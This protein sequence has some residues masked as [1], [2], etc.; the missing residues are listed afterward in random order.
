MD[1]NKL[2]DLSMKNIEAEL[3]FKNAKIVNVFSHEIVNGDVAINEGIIVGI[4]SYDGKKNI[5]IEGKYI[6][7]GLIDSHLHIESVMVTPQ[8][9]AKA[10]VPRGTTTAISDPH[11]IA[12]VCGLDG[13]DYML[14][15]SKNLPIDIYF[16]LPSCVPA[17][18]FEDSGA[19]LNANELKDL[20]NNARVLG[21]GEMMN[22]PGVIYKD[23][24]VIEKLELASKNNKIIDGHGPNISNEKL[25]AYVISGVSTEH[26]CSTVE[27]MIDRIRLGMYVMIR[28]GSAAKNLE[29]LVNGINNFNYQRCL[30]CTDDRHPQEILSSGHINNNV[31]LAIK[32]GI[33]PIT[34]IQIATINAANCY[35]LSKVG[36]ISPGYYADLLIVDDLKEF[37]IKEVYK[38]GRLVAKNEEALFDTHITDNSKVINTINMTDIKEKDLDIYLKNDTANVIK[39]I[40]NSLVTEKVSRKVD[41]EDNKFKY[42]EKLDI[43][44]LVVVERHKNTGN[45][46]LGLIENFKLKNGAIASTISH[47]SH[48]VI[49]VGDNDD[50]ILKAIKEVKEIGGGIA[51][52]YKN[53][54]VD[55]L[56]LNIGGIMSDKDIKYV[57]NKLNNMINIAYNKLNVNKDIDPFMTLSFLALPV[58]PKIKLTDKG[59]FDVDEFRFIEI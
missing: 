56:A 29:T 20:I 39:V 53:T 47:D 13:I 48:N 46:G 14:K 21:L 45:I 38:K 9:F 34:A 10:V 11:E 19:I 35:K 1:I 30:F 37:N 50:D 26:E 17:T 55:S 57:N 41:V 7:P 12:N 2:I 42:N 54:V 40:G 8:E 27:E 25:N 52:V 44:K 33:D 51:V 43:L 36:A 58:I 24:N 28:E 31:K 4:G 5:D 32:N 6:V 49:V 15:S 59:L 16:M 23:K 22:Y 3:V 18:D